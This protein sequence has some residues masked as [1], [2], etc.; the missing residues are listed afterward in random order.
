MKRKKPTAD[1]GSGRGGPLREH[2]CMKVNTAN[3][4][5]QTQEEVM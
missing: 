1:P 2:T 5:G 4:R 3:P